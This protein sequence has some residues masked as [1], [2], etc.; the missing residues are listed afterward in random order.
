MAVESDNLILGLTNEEKKK[1]VEKALATAKES[2]APYSNFHVGAIILATGTTVEGLN[3]VEEF[4]GINIENRSY[5]LTLCAERVAISKAVQAGFS[6]IKVIIVASPDSGDFLPPC[7]A[8]RQVLS[9]FSTEATVLMG[10]NKG[11]FMEKKLSELY[12]YDS[13]HNL[14]N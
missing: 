11:D 3:K 2:Y 8:C 7:G 9:E 4:T 6:S 5:G 1:L 13:L 10:N 12:P 14:K